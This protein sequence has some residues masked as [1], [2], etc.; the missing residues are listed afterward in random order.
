M[1]QIGHCTQDIADSLSHNQPQSAAEESHL[2]DLVRKH[3]EMERIYK[4]LMTDAGK[5]AESRWKGLEVPRFPRSG[6]VL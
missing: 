6:K 5:H 4:T 2:L 3:Q 1:T